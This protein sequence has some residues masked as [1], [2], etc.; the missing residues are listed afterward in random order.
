MISLTGW[1]HWGIYEVEREGERAAYFPSGENTVGVDMEGL[2]YQI[3]TI[4]WGWN[5]GLQQ[6]RKEDHFRWEGEWELEMEG[7]K[8]F[9]GHSELLVF[10][11][12]RKALSG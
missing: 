2:F 9:Q 6:L 11:L 4:K 3:F 8:T 1:V 7:E 5:G 10:E 12:N